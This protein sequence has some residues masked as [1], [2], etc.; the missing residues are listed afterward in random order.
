M[1]VAEI[2]YVVVLFM[3]LTG[4]GMGQQRGMTAVEKAM[5]R[6]PAAPRLAPDGE[7]VAFTI[8]EAD[9]AANRWRTQVYVVDTRSRAV[10]QV[11]Q[12]DASCGDV[13][14]S[15]DGR[16]LSFLSARPF[17]DRDGKRQ[18]GKTALFGMPADGGEATLLASL[19]GDIETYAWSPDGKH[20][21][22]LTE[23]AAPAAFVD[24]SHRREQRKLNLTA[25][26]D[27]K[28]GKELWLL[29]PSRGSAHKVCDLDPGAAEF[30]WFPA[31]D[32]LLYQTNYTGE[33]DDEQKWD[34]WSVTLD[35]R[36][37]QLTDMPGPESKGRVSP[38]GKWIACVTQTVP[39]IEFAKTEISLLNIE[40][41][42]FSRLTAEATY[43]VEDFRWSPSGD[44]L[45]ALFNERSSA[46]LYR[47]DPG[48]GVLRRTDR[49]RDGCA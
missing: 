3:V 39:D 23:A 31:G 36:K 6:Q 48:S 41:R 26:S 32:R 49:C 2:T 17:V 16:V 37:E 25:S 5:L 4:V 33:Y 12:S 14:W 18:E 29:D 34:L 10:R 38:D 40:S 8:R 42:Q 43:S 28:N 47:V 44:A 35:G 21:A 1:R 20:I 7:S 19:G 27:P 46:V 45:I 15:P 11:T 13:A 30:S 24:E 9:T 22:L